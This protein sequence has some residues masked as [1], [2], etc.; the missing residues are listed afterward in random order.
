MLL[1]KIDTSTKRK[2]QNRAAQRAFR[3]RREQLVGGL[4]ERIQ[5]LEEQRRLNAKDESS[6]VKE[7]A[8]LME[9]LERLKKEN[10][11]LKRIRLQQAND[12]DDDHTRCDKK[13]C[14]TGKCNRK[15]ICSKKSP[16]EPAPPPPVPISFSSS[17]DPSS[18][19]IPTISLFDDLFNTLDLHHNNNSTTH[20]HQHHQGK[21]GEFIDPILICE[22]PNQSC[23]TST[24]EN[25]N[26][27]AQQPQPHT[28]LD[29]WLADISSTVN[30]PTL[31]DTTQHPP[32]NTNGR[33]SYNA[34]QCDE[35]FCDEFRALALLS[36]ITQ[37]E[38]EAFQARSKADSYHGDQ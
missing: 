38:L 26:A 31:P 19:N 20:Q 17:H 35:N 32:T 2:A 14:P 18:N 28:I 13:S 33:S 36:D 4:Q 34:P 12:N 22:S 25:D 8:S 6:L 3:E 24:Y 5:Q 1:Q 23:S 7:N 9:E 11:S 27:N 10:T 15:R 16:R 37:D 29:Q 30:N 21:D